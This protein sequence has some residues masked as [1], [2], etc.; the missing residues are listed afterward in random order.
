MY[1]ISQ[2]LPKSLCWNMLSTSHYPMFPMRQ[3]LTFPNSPLMVE[4]IYLLKTTLISFGANASNMT[5]QIQE[6]YADYLLLLLEVESNIGLNPFHHVTFF[7]G[8]NLQMSFQMLLKFMILINYVKNFI[9]ANQRRFIF[10]RLFDKS[11][12]YPL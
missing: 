4:A 1:S 5:S 10:R 3:S 2:W 6:F 12:S 11:L 8:F 7:I 9:L